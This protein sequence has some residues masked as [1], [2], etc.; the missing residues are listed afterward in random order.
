MNAPTRDNGFFTEALTN[1]DPEIAGAIGKELGRQR[2]E[3][4]LIASENIVSKAVLEAQGTV[5][6]NKYAEGYPGKRYYGGCQYVDIVENLAIERAKKLFDC[7]FANVQPNSGSQMNQAVFLALLKPGD[8]FMGLDLNSGGHLTHGSP[9]NMSGKWF[10]VL[11]YGVRQQDQLLDMEAVAE[12]A[13]QHKPKLILAGGTA[14]SR[15]WDW[16]AFRKIADEVGAYLMVDMAHI[17][18]LVAGGQHPSPLPHA[19][20]VTTT[21]HKSLRGPRGGMVLTN[22]ADIAKKINSAVFPGLQ[23]GPLMHVIA[24]KAVAFGEALEPSF[25]DYAAQVVTNARAMADELMKGGIDI[26]SGG[27]DNHLCLADLRPK[28]VTGKAT[29]AA[30]GRAHIT[31]NKN[32][33]PFDPE[34]PFVTSGIRLGTPAGTTRGF[35][36]AEFRLIARWIVEVVDGLAANGEEGNGA[37][38]DKVRAEVAELC[39][40]FPLY[41]DL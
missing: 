25:K 17:A 11:S 30:L 19:H 23:G 18:G 12:A 13:R 38:E 36:E 27:T 31:C 10:N 7:E 35:G 28:G 39:A 29:E 1:R 40:R 21:T 16:A 14:Y 8:T 26:V 5:L 22:D 6:T 33:V 41:P 4:E 3:I 20:V 34:K 9:V 2:D 15:I 32:G 24:A 37:T